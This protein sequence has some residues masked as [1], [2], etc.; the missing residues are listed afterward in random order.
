MKTTIKQ[1]EIDCATS[2]LPEWLEEFTDN[3]QDAVVPAPANTS[4]DSDSE[5]PAKVASRKHSFT[6]TS[7][8]TEIAKSANEPKL[9]GLFPGSEL[10]KRYLEYKMLVT[11]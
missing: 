7:Q 6:L 5:R 4:D 9:Q 1:R 2:H 10:V 8:K 3:L 11:L